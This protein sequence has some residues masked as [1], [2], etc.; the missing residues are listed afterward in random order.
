M[1]Y[2]K[3]DWT[4]AMSSEIFREYAKNELR[5]EATQVEESVNVDDVLDRFAEVEEMI[6]SNPKA[7][8]EFKLLKDKLLE[9]PEY[10]SKVNKKFADA[11]LLLN[12]DD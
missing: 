7:K 10:A 6:R 2:S 12:L 1:A 11:V 8:A 5:K 9:D 3:E 4:A